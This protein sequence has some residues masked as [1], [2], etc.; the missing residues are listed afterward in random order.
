[1]VVRLVDLLCV[2]TIC[3]CASV[4][5]PVPV[6]TPACAVLGGDPTSVPDTLVYDTL[7]VSQRPFSMFLPDFRYPDRLRQAGIEGR[8]VA[9]LVVDATGRAEPSSIR[10][11]SAT[12][13]D[14]VAPTLDVLRGAR[15]CPGA[16]GDR[17]VRVRI[18]KALNYTIARR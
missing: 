13:Q 2:V 11:V 12:H 4:R 5:Q 3:A 15:F 8:V 14:F 18:T 16:I 9:E 17:V 1:M 10:V 7:S 6:P